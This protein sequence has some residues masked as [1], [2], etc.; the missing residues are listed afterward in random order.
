MKLSRNSFLDEVFGWFDWLFDAIGVVRLVLL[1]VGF[2]IV[3]LKGDFSTLKSAA[4]MFGAFVTFAAVMT[5]S[6]LIFRGR[7]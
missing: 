4:I 2:L 1:I 6:S 5:L 3:L 7:S